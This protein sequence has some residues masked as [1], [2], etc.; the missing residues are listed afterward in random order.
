MSEYHVLGLEILKLDKR[1][2]KMQ[3]EFQNPIEEEVIDQNNMEIIEDLEEVKLDE[4]ENGQGDDHLDHCHDVQRTSDVNFSSSSI[5]S[6]S[7]LLL[8]F[9][10][11]SQSKL[12]A[13]FGSAGND[14]VSFGTNPRSNTDHIVSEHDNSKVPLDSASI[15]ST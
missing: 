3:N 2:D 14:L 5:F 9:G 1:L 8:S 15:Y 13:F 12:S 4:E 7:I 10:G 11:S 6:N